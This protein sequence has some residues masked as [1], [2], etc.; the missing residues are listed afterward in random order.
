VKTWHI[1]VVAAASLLLSL[2]VMWAVV[3]PKGPSIVN[4]PAA[5]AE[6]LEREHAATAGKPDAKVHIVE[7]L[8]PA[9]ET[10]REFY[11]LVKTMLADNPDKIRLSVRLVAFHKGSDFVVKALEASKKQGK[12]WQVLERVLASQPLWAVQHVV[13]PELAWAQLAPLG[14]NLD[15]LKADMESPEVMRAMALDAQDARALKVTQ[16]PEYFVNGRSMST[17]G[18][19]QLRQLVAEAMASAYR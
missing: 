19:E 11:P 3:A 2:G 10:C 1:V 5:A 8:D 13:K 4:P 6:S 14:L 15:Q 18:Y 7:F 12:F 17:F 16:T 9:C